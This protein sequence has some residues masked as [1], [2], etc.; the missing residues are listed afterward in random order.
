MVASVLSSPTTPVDFMVHSVFSSAA[1]AVYIM[2]PSVI[3]SPATPVF[4]C[5]SLMFLFSSILG[6]FRFI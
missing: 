5:G 2:A 6:L 3:S 4:F 1:A